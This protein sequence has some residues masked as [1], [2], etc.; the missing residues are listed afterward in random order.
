MRVS[1][2]FALPVL[3]L[4]SPAL[5]ESSRSA[6][7]IVQDG[8]RFL[9][10]GA[11]S[12][13]ARAYGEAID[14]D[15]N[16][17][18]N[19][20]KRA[21]AYLSMGRH[22]AALDDFDQILKIN[23]A[24]AQAH[25]QKAKIL[26]KEGEFEK[27]KSELKAYGKSKKDVESDELLESVD[28]AIGASKSAHKAAQMKNWV[29]CVDHST[30]ALELGPNSAELRE[31]RVQ[32]ATELGD[33]DAVYG[34]L[35]RLA[36]LNPSTLSLPLRLSH[37]AY[38]LLAS[39]S[40][41]NHIKQCLHY[42]PDSRPCKVVHKLLRRLEKDTAKARNFVEGG[43]W[44]Q[45]IKIFDG[46]EGLLAQFDQALEE[47]SEG[48]SSY[49]PKQ[50]HPREKSLK[51]LELYALACKAAV[52][53][54]DFS[55]N[56]GTKWCE[57][58]LKMDEGN[59]DALVARG[60]KL[61]KEENWE[62]AVRVLER[63]FEN[64]GRSSQDILN[65]VQKAQRLLK[66]SKQKDYYKVLGVPRDADERTIKK[67]FRTAAKTAHPDVGGSEEKMATLNEAYE[68][69]SNPELRQ[70]YD[71]GDDPNDPH[72]GQ[73]HN[74]FAHHG[75]GMPFQFFQQGGF[76]QGFPGGHAQGQKMHFQWG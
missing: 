17:Y 41:T 60:E 52:G 59:A 33:V 1:P 69:L 61:L 6:S 76:Q 35:S 48:E 8:N 74:P 39:P 5:G 46:P 45:A 64:S 26:A 11:Y 34:D 70:R 3:L 43:A 67:A 32:C 4:L 73:Q 53:A 13:A 31:L 10:E 40:A 20:Y 29:I 7:R 72:Q 54:G 47:A 62:E 28:V 16:S 42:D 55:K 14:L 24:F 51:R 68:V 19:Y 36:A 63:A 15:P 23:P 12:E 71:N 58:T 37:I 38:F 9:A 56:K 75:G 30:K 18:V 57:E 66:Q 22:G 44:R 50:F 65:R 27:S 2:I 49:L 21:T 25:L